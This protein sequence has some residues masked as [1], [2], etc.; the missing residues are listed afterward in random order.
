MLETDIKALTAAVVALNETMQKIGFPTKP[1]KKAGD[2]DV[3]IGLPTDPG[4]TETAAVEVTPDLAPLTGEPTTA[5]QEPQF[6]L[7][8]VKQALTKIV[9]THPQKYQAATDILSRVGVKTVPELNENQYGAVIA[10]C[11]AVFK[12]EAI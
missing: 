7:D 10:K 6:T 3:N 11:A 5:K 2:E 12:G 9:Q 8:Q 1:P 4:K